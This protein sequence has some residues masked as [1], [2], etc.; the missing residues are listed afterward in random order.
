MKRKILAIAVALIFMLSTW[1]GLDSVLA[2]E[3]DA[4]ADV[5][6]NEV[7]DSTYVQLQEVL[8][9]IAVNIEQPTKSDV[10][11]TFNYKKHPESY[12]G[13]YVDGD[14]VVVLMKNGMAKHKDLENFI[15][16]A[17]SQG[18][19]VV[20]TA[21]YSFN[22]LN[23]L[24][25][26][27]NLYKKYNKDAIAKQ[28][29]LYWLDVMNNRIVVE[30]DQYS[31]EVVSQFKSRVSDSD[32]IFFK[33]LEGNIKKEAKLKCGNKISSNSSNSSI[34][35]RAKLG[36]EEGIVVSGH[37]AGSIGSN[38]YHYGTYC[39]KVKKLQVYGPVD[40]AFVKVSSGFVPSN[41]L[42]NSGTYLS[43]MLSNPGVG[44]YVNKRGYKT[45]HTGGHIL[46]TN[47]TITLD[48]DH[49]W[50]LSSANYQSDHGDSGGI[51]Y[52]YISAQNK[53]LTVGLHVAAVGNTRYYSK[54]SEVNAALGV[55][56][57]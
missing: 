1:G 15:R 54:A 27:L 46:S 12:A 52:T 40:A 47:V 9:T 18:R 41:E 45:G 50:N 20:F 6:V 5:P 19:V 53:R 44:T 42:Q 21:R 49:H 23:Y 57:Y 36:N 11:M 43:T 8:E 7:A 51:V 56:R 2:A 26:T 55:T 22:E 14:K 39:G 34:S 29:N 17:R 13:S 32:A 24:M 3:A 16:E 48:G 4:D 30:L 10:D 37:A 25:N 31:E 28:F 35:Y 38:F 33:Q